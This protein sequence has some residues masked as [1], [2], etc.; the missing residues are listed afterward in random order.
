MKDFDKQ[1]IINAITEFE[2][3][4]EKYSA[5][6][7]ELALLKILRPLLETEG[8]VV[9]HTAEEE[10]VLGVDFIGMKE[11]EKLGIE[12]KHYRNGSAGTDEVEELIHKANI[13][14]LDRVIFLAN[15]S[16]SQHT[17]AFANAVN[18][19][20]L[21]L[22]D[23]DGLKLWT[24]RVEANYEESEV[25]QVL[26]SYVSKLIELIANSSKA[27]AEIEWRDIERV[28]AEVFDGLGFDAKL[29]PASKDGGKDVILECRAKGT[30]KSYIVEIKHWRSGQ[31]VGEGKIREFLQVITREK[32][33][34]GLFLSTYGFVENAVESLTQIDREKVKFG[35]ETKI[36]TLCKTYIKKKAGLWQSEEELPVILFEDTV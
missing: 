35:T 34:G 2:R 12:Y 9:S 27:L 20:S 10:K 21:E 14:S 13:V 22:L 16:F 36:A 26:R 33:D 4:Q 19:I 25:I 24:S 32:R 6:E 31:R 8:Y 29:T 7:A 18:P 1:A 17:R 3:Q 30:R 5:H 28:I 23:I 11:N 15:K